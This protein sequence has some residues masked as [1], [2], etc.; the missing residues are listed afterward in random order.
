MFQAR[1]WDI[2]L[3]VVDAGVSDEYTQY[4]VAHP[5]LDISDPVEPIPDFEEERGQRRR[6]GGGQGSMIGRRGR[7]DGGDRGGGE[8]GGGGGGGGGDL[9]GRV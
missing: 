5:I 4:M 1:P 3:R 8:G 7:G 6:R 9:G 2:R